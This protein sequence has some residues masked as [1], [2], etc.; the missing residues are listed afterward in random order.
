MIRRIGFIFF[1]IIFVLFA[2]ML[3]LVFTAPNISSIEQKTE[4]NAPIEE[5]WPLVST[6][7]NRSH[8]NPFLEGITNLSTNTTGVDGE[9]GSVF[10]WTSDQSIGSQTITELVPFQRFASDL[11][12]QTPMEGAAKESTNLTSLPN[13]HTEV[14]WTYTQSNE[15]FIDKLFVGLGFFKKIMNTSY[16]KGL[17]KLK[18]IAE[19]K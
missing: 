11:Y 6:F 17:E 19:S 2:V 4:I 15:K 18:G 7:E 8:W 14:S 1:I 5:V 10:N 16:A 13:G 3:I 12:F 9:V